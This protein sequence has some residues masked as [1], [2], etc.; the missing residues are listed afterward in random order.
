MASSADLVAL[1]V[2]WSEW[3]DVM[4][5]QLLEIL[6]FRISVMH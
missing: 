2:N 5:D 4:S 1:D 6:E 3:Q